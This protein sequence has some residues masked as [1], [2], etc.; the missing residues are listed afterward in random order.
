M[1]SPKE[2]PLPGGEITEGAIDQ[3]LVPAG[4]PGEDHLETD[5][6]LSILHSARLRI[7]VGKRSIAHGS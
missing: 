3:W 4:E 2:E 6:A 7:N 1:G 5:D